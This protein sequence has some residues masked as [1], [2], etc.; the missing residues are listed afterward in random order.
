[1]SFISWLRS[2]K[3]RDKAIRSRRGRPTCRQE[4]WSFR[5]RL[6]ALEDRTLLS[7]VNW[8]AGSGDWATPGNWQDS[9]TLTNHVPGAADDAVINAAG[10]TVTHSSGNFDAI[11][12]LT[13]GNNRGENLA[14]SAGTLSLASTSSLNNNTLTLSGGTLTGAG[15]LSV[16]GLFTWTGGTLSGSGRLDANGGMVLDPS[17]NGVVLDRVLNNAGT[18][19][20]TDSHGGMGRYGVTLLTG[21]VVNNLAGATFTSDARGP[22]GSS[23]I[24]NGGSSVPAFNNYGTFK[25]SGGT[26][27]TTMLLPFNNYGT[28]QLQSATLSL[29][30]QGSTS[31]GSFEAVDGTTLQLYG[32]HNLTTT[33]SINAD[34]VVFLGP[35]DT[36]AGSYRSR[37]STNVL[38]Q[39]GGIGVTFTGTI[40]GIG[41]L[42]LDGGAI[43][44][45]F[46]PASGSPIALTS[47]TL[48]TGATLTG[49]AD[50]V[51]SGLFA[52]TGATLAGTGSYNYLRANGGL[53]LS[54]SNNL[55]GRILANAGS[56]AWTGGSLYATNGS[57]SGSPNLIAN[58]AGAT[59]D[60]QADTNLVWSGG[61]LAPIF[62]NAG[63]FKKSAGTGTTSFQT[64]FNNAGTV[65]VQSGTLYLTTPGAFSNNTSG[66]VTVGS[67]STLQV[68]GDYTQYAGLTSLAGGVLGASGTV[69]IQGG[70][71]SGYGTINASVINAGVLSVG[72]A[73]A[74]G[75]LSIN[76]NYTQTSGGTLNIRLGGTT[77]GSQYDQLIVTGVATLDGTLNV[78]LI[79]GFVPAPGNSFKVLTFGSRTGNFA[80][81]NGLNLGGGHSLTPSYDPVS[82]NFVAI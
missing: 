81:M 67:G 47:L 22:S 57:L 65:N 9:T 20:W 77:A 56:A 8:I 38:G 82:L 32:M 17:W 40:V 36:V 26:Y 60:V 37:T 72:A 2:L 76:G 59:F 70:T 74:T 50:F 68:V 71:L 46:S 18:A 28:V 51:V 62:F 25:K 75:T 53:A 27:V 16:S 7:V 45:Y 69:N 31:S 58:L 41:A 64:F 11:N 63:T 3:S 48:G 1:M 33:S 19:T 15:N 14:I 44:A 54:G 24:F 35:T 49:T 43:T 5:P 12:S 30:W 55:S 61:S 78:S 80:T 42:T 23:F 21:G 73:A 6:E 79:N 4:K 52:W 66:T 39:A 10:I 29:G 13:M 34:K